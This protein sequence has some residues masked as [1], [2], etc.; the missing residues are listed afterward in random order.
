[1]KIEDA[2]T[3]VSEDIVESARGSR[4]N[5]L[6]S[7]SADNKSEIVYL[8]IDLLVPYRHQARVIFNEADIYEM[9]KTIAIHGIRQPLTVLRVGDDT[10][11]FEVVSGERR[12]RAARLLGLLKV[13]CI[14]I[15]DPEKAEEIALI[16]NVQ[17]KSL[18]PLELA[19]SLKA[20]A[21]KRGW[22]GQE[23]LC[24][25]IGLSSSQLS[26]LLKLLSL[27]VLV[28]DSL[29]RLNIRGREHFRKLFK[30]Q[31]VQEQLAYISSCADDGE[32]SKKSRSKDATRSVLRV[33]LTNDEL[34]IQKKQLHQL[35]PQMK[36]ELCDVLN[37][38]IR[39]LS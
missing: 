26:E 24:R 32:D 17:R 8:S 14:I 18:H 5:R 19:R 16:E 27:S 36:A 22:G 30:L 35:S 4:G 34:R 11:Q 29:L 6:S 39:E 15:D 7:F 25:K 37:G 33:S 20:L 28:Q 13:P 3:R 1:M 12:L 38:V 9:S 31:T 23:E 21:T 10:V 2:K